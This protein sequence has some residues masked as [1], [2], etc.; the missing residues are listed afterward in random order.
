MVGKNKNILK[1]TNPHICWVSTILVI[2]EKTKNTKERTLMSLLLDGLNEE[3]KMAVSHIDGPLLV[4]AC[5][6]SGK[7]KTMTH[8]AGYLIEN[9]ISAKSILMLTFTNKAAQEMKERLELLLGNDKSEDVTACTFHSFC[10][11]MLR[12]HGRH[13]DLSPHFSILS[14]SDDE[15]VISIAKTTGDKTRYKGRG[16]PPNKQIVGFISMSI[17]KNIDLYDVMKDTKYSDFVSEVKE[18]NELAQEYRK[19]HNMLNY[20]DILVRFIDLIVM[21]PSICKHIA[22]TYQYIMVDE[23]QD[24][25][26]LQETILLEL[27]KYTKNIAVVGDDMQSLYGFRGAEVENIIHF[28]DRFDGT[29]T[30]ILNKNYRS[31]QEILDIGNTVCQ[32]A[33]EGIYKELIGTYSSGEKPK[34]NIVDDQ[35]DEANYICDEIERLHTREGVSLNQICIIGRNSMMS[36][37]LEVKLNNLGYEFDKYGGAKFTDLS[38]VK[39][40][41]SYLKVMTNPY[42]EIAWFRILQI[43]KGIGP[44]NARK[45]AN[46][47]RTNGFKVLIDKSYAKKQYGEELLRLN[48]IL[49]KMDGE[50]LN[51]MLAHFMNFYYLTKKKNIEDMDVEDEGNRTAYLHDLENEKQNLLKLSE[52]AKNYKSVDSFLDDLLL[53]NTKAN[54][55]DSKDETHLVISTI[56]SVKGLEFDAVFMLD[57]VDGLFPNTDDIGSKEDNEELRCFYVAVTRAKKK[58]Y[59][60]CPRY[61]QKFGQ[62]FYG[63]PSRYISELI[64]KRNYW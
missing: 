36:A 50:T 63:N 62:S 51:I 10:A 2:R 37:G 41:L 32:H 29:E 40:V 48:T 42:D 46:K 53:D 21:H 61:C 20:D 57:C 43:H 11:M 17:N 8:R 7:T 23:Y 4:L 3:Q 59:I 16:F 19:E 56:H 22:N 6:G 64:T 35:Y 58:L 31:C 5:A 24:T 60:I 49:E 45:I 55:K 25:N 1:N 14:A 38:Y 13:I 27:F 9:G 44:V 28:P 26:P 18:L 54:D 30:I 33:T 47:C 15:D 52:I 12:I 34:I 39:D